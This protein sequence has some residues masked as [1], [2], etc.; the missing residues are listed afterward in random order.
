MKQLNI[1]IK[2]AFVPNGKITV[3][4]E[5]IKFKKD[6]Y[7]NYTYMHMSDKNEAVIKILNYLDINRRMWFISNML[8]FLI[9]FFGLFDQR[10]SKNCVVRNCEF[11]VKLEKDITNIDI[12]TYIGANKQG[13]ATVVC[14]APYAPVVNS[15]YV[16][17]VAKRRYKI[18]K[19][20]KILTT[21][22]IVAVLLAMLYLT[23]NP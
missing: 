7:G 20:T 8:C 17:E 14:D 19:I 16:D 4:D 3:D 12:N 18:L 15:I 10:V 6:S 13:S 23:M 1:K 11:R 9:S 5:V 2:M 22:A 21:I